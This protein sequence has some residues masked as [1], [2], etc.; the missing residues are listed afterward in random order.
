MRRFSDSA[1]LGPLGERRFFLLFTGRTISMLGSTIAPVALAFA[2]VDLTGSPSDLGLVLAAS[3]VPQI[4]FLVVGGVW[5]DRVPRHVVMVSADLVGAAA[6]GTLAVLLLTGTAQVWHIVCVACVRGVAAAFFMPAS[7]GVVPQTVSA[8]QLQ[9]ANAIL[10]FS[11]NT[12]AILGAAGGGLLVA[13]LGPGLALA[14]DAATYVLGACFLAFLK[15]PPLPAARRHFVRELRE[16]WSEFRGR[17]W[18]WAVVVQF[19]FINAF[20]WAAFFVLG[21]F[22]AASSL[23][24]PATW[25]LILTAEAAGMLVGGYIALRHRPRRPLLAG[26]AALIL[27]ALPLCALALASGKVVIGLAAFAAGVGV[28]F[29]EVLWATTLQS[30]I[31]ADRLSR[32]SSYDWLGSFALVPLGT[33][34]VGPLALTIGFANT[35]WIAAGVVVSSTLAVIAFGGVRQLVESPPAA[36][37]PPQRLSLAA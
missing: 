10:G 18:L 2:V 5:A 37:E 15:L 21:P 16:G 34:L 7:T 11:R 26:N 3:F 20:S 19:T 28:E 36:A 22:I 33:I 23:G 31:P 14:V 35:L 32:V 24:G 1:S 8:G 25:G 9:Q 4:L 29:F 17:K 27:I 6:Q 12:T 13:G 30:R